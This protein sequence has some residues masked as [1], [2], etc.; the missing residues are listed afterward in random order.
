MFLPPYSP[1]LNPIE[2][3]FSLLKAWLHRH[4]HLV[5]GMWPK[6]VM[7]VALVCCTKVTNVGRRSFAHSGYG[8]HTFQLP[9]G[10]EASVM[11]ED[12]LII[13]FSEE[14]DVDSD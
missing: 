10:R 1:H 12:G 9:A 13:V 14:E 4:A 6:E 11:G 5:Y 2:T 8:D 3:A 7:D